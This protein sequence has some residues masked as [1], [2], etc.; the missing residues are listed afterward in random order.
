MKYQYKAFII[1][2]GA[3]GTLLVTNELLDIVWNTLHLSLLA[4][5]MYGTSLLVHHFTVKAS[6]EN[7]KRFPAYFMAITGLKMMAYII[8]L[9]VYVF[10]FKETAIPVVVAF[11]LL[12]L[13]FTLLEVL[14]AVSELKSDG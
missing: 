5:F 3:F 10:V 13:A 14:S 9:G 11:L 2:L 6:E 12:Y 7:P 1:L 4:L 8:M